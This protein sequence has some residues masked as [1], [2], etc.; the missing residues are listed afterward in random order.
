MNCIDRIETAE[1]P[2]EMAVEGAVD[3]AMERAQ[4][5]IAALDLLGGVVVIATERVELPP[6]G[7]KR[8]FATKR[9]IF[10]YD[11][12]VPAERPGPSPEG[13][14]PDPA[15]SPPEPVAAETVE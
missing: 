3:E 8:Q 13:P 10:Q 5:A 9:F 11:S 6:L 15:P 1:G 12:F 4:Q 14:R 2:V 7:D